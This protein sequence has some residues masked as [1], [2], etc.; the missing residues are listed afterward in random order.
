ME[1]KEALKEAVTM[2][3]SVVEKYAHVIKYPLTYKAELL[4]MYV[5]ISENINVDSF[6]FKN[7]KLCG[8][9][10]IDE[11]EKTIVFNSNHPQNRRNFTLAHELGHYFLH[12][13]KQ[14]RFHDRS[15]D[16]LDNTDNIIEM[17]ANAFAAQLVIPKI[18]LFTMLKNRYSFFRISKVS[19][20]SN[21]ALYWILVN[22]LTQELNIKQKDAVLIVEDF[23]DFSTGS[24][25]NL[26]H[27]NYSAIYKINTKNCN[28]VI[29]GL[30]NGNKPFYFER[31]LRGDITGVRRLANN[32]VNFNYE[33]F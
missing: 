28:R 22:L 18:I 32:P 11:H 24:H 25:K 15:K 31:N 33:L 2:A 12:S 7:N 23:K 17:Q 30:K 29:K 6:P 5:A 20:V 3:D 10:C 21:D 8:M 13:E 16:L 26:V 4:I 1:K 9:L 14:K 27:H 19:R